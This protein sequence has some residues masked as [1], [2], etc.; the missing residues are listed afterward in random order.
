MAFAIP[1]KGDAGNASSPQRRQSAPPAWII[2]LA[3]IVALMFVSPYALVVS[4]VLISVF[5][6]MRPTIAIV[7]GVSLALVIIMTIHER[8]RGRPF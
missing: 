3:I 2:P 1:Q 7:F 6:T 4:I 8:W 5:L